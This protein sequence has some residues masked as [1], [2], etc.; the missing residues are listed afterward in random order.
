MSKAIS[1]Y[2][3]LW[4]SSALAFQGDLPTL[5]AARNQIR[6]GFRV[7]ANQQL[8]G[9]EIDEKIKY[10]YD[11]ATILRRNVVQ[12]APKD[13]SKERYGEL[14]STQRCCALSN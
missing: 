4:R 1:A 8:S 10:A 11:V 12:A 7:P 2:R 5:I 3:Y 9:E 13:G 14:Q 6:D